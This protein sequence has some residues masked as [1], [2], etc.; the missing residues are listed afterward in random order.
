[1]DETERVRRERWL[2]GAVLGGD[3][4]A[5]RAWYEEHCAALE[6]YVH[7]RCGGL[8]DLAEEVLQDTWLTAVRAMRRFCPEAGSF[9]QWLFG[10]A[11]NTVRNHVR[12]WR[13]RS[14][15]QRAITSPA[16]LPDASTNGDEIEARAQ[17]VAQALAALPERYE[18]VLRAKYLEQQSVE[19]IAAAWGDTPKAIESLLTR[20]REAFREAYAVEDMR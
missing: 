7:W 13:R 9:R 10:V 14:R 19:A 18:Q 6:A 20:A 3:E 15:R 4:A 16:S 12:A 2:R 8:R 1:M 17:V 11:A 5:W